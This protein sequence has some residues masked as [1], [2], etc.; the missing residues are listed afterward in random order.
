MTNHNSRDPDIGLINTVGIIGEAQVWSTLLVKFR[1]IALDP[2]KHGRMID[3]AASFPQEFFHITIAQ[4]IP[5][6][7][8]HRA[9]DD[10]GFKVAPFEWGSIAHGQPPVIGDRYG[11]ARCSR[12]LAILVTEP[13]EVPNHADLRIIIPAYI[14]KHI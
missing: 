5:Q 3:G 11:L 12:S 1:G 14:E 2:A 7:P 6:V 13:L 9:E 10:V 4:G 8:P